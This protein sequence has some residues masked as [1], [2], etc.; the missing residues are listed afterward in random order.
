MKKI[1]KI[2][3]VAITVASIYPISHLNISLSWWVYLLLFFSP[4]IGIL[5]YTISNKVGA[6]SYN[7]LHHRGIAI[8]VAGLGLFYTNDYILLSG[9][10]L[11]AHASFD[12]I[13][14]FG[15]KHSNGFKY[16]HLGVLK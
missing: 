14:G 16:T 8:A 12:R 3:E 4:D 5:G 6:V 10:I 9:L 15:L 2:E 13:F 1:I 11:L 7:I